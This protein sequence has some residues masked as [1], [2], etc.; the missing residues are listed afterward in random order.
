MLNG[1]R[2]PLRTVEDPAYV[3]SLANEMDD[4]LR[5]LMGETSLSLTEALILLGLEYLDANKKADGTLDNMR[6]QVADY[7]EAVK[8]AEQELSEAKE[9]IK[10]L[11][12]LPG[13][14]NPLVGN[15][16]P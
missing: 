10:R 5:K 7:M 9:K 12:T 11:S 4:T 3:T 15:N 2:Y 16:K 1:V 14:K 13:D 6:R 8:R